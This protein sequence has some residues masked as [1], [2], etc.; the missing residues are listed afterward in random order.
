MIDIEKL[1]T[2]PMGIDRIRRNLDLNVED[3]VG[4]SIIKRLGFD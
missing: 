3:V 2:T 1:H 4:V